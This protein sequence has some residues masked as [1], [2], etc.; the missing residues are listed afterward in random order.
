MGGREGVRLGETEWQREEEREEEHEKHSKK[1]VR[2]KTDLQEEGDR[3]IPR[4]LKT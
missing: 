3:I 2:I 1:I 4:S